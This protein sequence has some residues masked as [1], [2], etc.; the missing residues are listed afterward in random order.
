MD[1]LNEL[2]LI[3]IR[4]EEVTKELKAINPSKAYGPDQIPGRILK[5]CAYEIAPSLTHLINLSLRVGCV[6]KDWKR[7]NIVPVY[8]KGNKED[9][10]NYR[11]ISLLSLVSKI[12]E[13]CVF[14][15]FYSFIA[16]NIY[17]LQHGFVKGRSTVTQLLDTVHRITSAIDQGVQTDVAFLD[18]SKAFDSVS[19]PHLISKLDQIGIKGP[20]LQ[21][22]TSYLNNRVQRVV[23]DGKNS[24]WLPVTS[25]VPQGS[26][27]GPALFVLFINDMPRAVSQCSTLALF[28]DDAKCF[29]T[30]RSASDC[31]RFQGDIDN[32]VEWSDVWMMA[33]N[34]D[35]CSLCTITRKRNPIIYDYNMRGNAL[36]RVEAQRDLG[37]LITSDA[38]FN[39]H[40]YAQVNKANRM[41]GFIR[42]TLS[43][44]CD[45][46]L[47]T[48][49]SLYLALVRSH[50]EYA[51]E[52][53]SPKSVT[54]IKLIEGVQ[55]RATRLLLPNLTYNDRLQQLN[56]LP[57]VYR[58]E[59]KDITTFFK[60]KCGL[61]NYP[62][63][64]YFESCSDKRLRSYTSNKLKINKVR[65]ELF[66]GTFFNRL[67]YLWNNLPDKLR[68]SNLSLS[69][70]KE[71]CNDFYKRKSFDPDYP[72][73]TWMY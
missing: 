24:E 2:H 63:E 39:E 64:S 37:V 16:G 26:L 27:L 11:P 59:V 47:P 34:M 73:A 53:W 70:F 7:A 23:I 65:T 17:P 15:P 43:S 41:L 51:S 1:K 3:Q 55:R 71:Q 72:H 30:I 52:I 9:V 40:I 29:R 33:F 60:L 56:L 20:L 6:P 45:Q 4:I 10:T 38:R 12:A 21:W 19:H 31:V 58:R 67:P 35:K 28:A 68:T 36:K 42:R 46:F 49:R 62:V 13:R 5:E 32:L 8:K 14:A 50:L 18:F 66:K 22:F 61:Y 57:L 48:F 44:R 54:L 25:G 69:L